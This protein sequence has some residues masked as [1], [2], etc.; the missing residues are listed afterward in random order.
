MD[1][2][3]RARLSAYSKIESVSG[4]NNNTLPDPDTLTPGTVIGVSQSGTFVPVGSVTQEDVDTLFTDVSK[5][6]QVVTKEEIDSLF[7]DQGTHPGQ[8]GGSCNPPCDHEYPETVTKEE[9]DSLF[10]K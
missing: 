10:K 5:D 3:L 6:P 1:I 8:G 4:L 7:S 9:I 2:K